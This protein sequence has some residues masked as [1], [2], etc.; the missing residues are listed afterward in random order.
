M[1]KNLLSPSASTLYCLLL[2]SHSSDIA[3][4]FLRHLLFYYYWIVEVSLKHHLW[5]GDSCTWKMRTD[6]ASNGV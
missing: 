1:N 3:Q 2:I 5:G 6:S 4:R